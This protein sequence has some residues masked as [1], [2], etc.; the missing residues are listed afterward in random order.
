M[1]HYHFHP[2]GRGVV[3]LRLKKEKSFP[4]SE[5]A[6]EEVGRTQLIVW[7]G[8]T[9]VVARV[10]D[11]VGGEV[12]PRGFRSQNVR[13]TAGGMKTGPEGSGCHWRLLRTIPFLIT[14]L[15]VMGFFLGF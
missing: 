8:W 11:A 5:V 13:K 12:R 4:Q 6:K 2:S 14:F 9:S 15:K 10:E 3:Y 7:W 1:Y